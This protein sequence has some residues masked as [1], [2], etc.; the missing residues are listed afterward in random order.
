MTAAGTDVVISGAGPTGLMLALW[1]TRLGVRV[2]VA[3]PK[4]GPVQETRA[5]AVQARTLEFYD[6]L[7]I[8]EEAMARGRHFAAIGLFV[9]GQRRAAVSLRGVGDDLTPHP[10]L[11]ILTQD[12]NEELLVAALAQLGVGV[13]WETEVTGL[14]QDD[15]GVSVTL[16]H[17][18]QDEV[19]PATYAAGCDGA[20]SV[21]RRALGIP[22]SGGTYSQR[23]FVAD[24]DA[25][26]A[27]R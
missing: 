6:Q 25:T 24:V 3:D 4:P 10:Y 9:N 2:R 16:H 7:G 20:G 1:L 18:G 15:A 26:G 27:I 22:L 12:Q 13:D 14:T 23:F 19:V 11:Y 17:A 8:G 5:I 21:V